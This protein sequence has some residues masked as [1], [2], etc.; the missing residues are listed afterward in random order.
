[1]EFG[2][3]ESEAEAGPNEEG[4]KAESMSSLDLSQSIKTQNASDHGRSSGEVDRM[5]KKFDRMSRQPTVEDYDSDGGLGS[6]GDR[7]NTGR[8]PVPFG[9]PATETMYA[10]TATGVQLPDEVE[11]PG[12]QAHESLAPSPRLSLESHTSSS[13]DGSN[14]PPG[15]QNKEP[16]K[17]RSDSRLPYSARSNTKSL[18]RTNTWDGRPRAESSLQSQNTSRKSVGNATSQGTKRVTFSRNQSQ[19][20]SEIDRRSS[21][22]RKELSDRRDSTGPRSQTATR[23]KSVR[24]ARSNNSLSSSE[25]SSMKGQQSFTDTS[26]DSD[27]SRTH[28]ANSARDVREPLGEDQSRSPSLSGISL[29][30]TKSDVGT[31]SDSPYVDYT[32]EQDY[33]SDGEDSWDSIE[34]ES[35]AQDWS[36]RPYRPRRASSAS[37]NYS[38]RRP[39]SH[40]PPRR[41]IFEVA[42]GY[43]PSEITSDDYPDYPQPSRASDPRFVAPGTPFPGLN[44]FYDTYPD[45]ASNPYAPEGGIYGQPFHPGYGRRMASAP[46]V[47]PPPPPPPPPFPSRAP[48]LPEL[49]ALLAPPDAPLNS[50][51]LPPEVPDAPSAGSYESDDDSRTVTDEPI[52]TPAHAKRFENASGGPP[53]AAVGLYVD[54]TSDVDPAR[55]A[56]LRFGASVPLH[57]TASISSPKW[58]E[59]SSNRNEFGHFHTYQRHDALVARRLRRGDGWQSIELQCRQGPPLP[60]L[61]GESQMEWL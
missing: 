13:T 43:A 9:G 20:S 39:R 34:A 46:F 56:Q 25:Q 16:R 50:E 52:N 47:S 7:G 61:D 36:S 45:Y 23:G 4:G 3:Q 11:E 53:D 6:S 17:K 57:L 38:L 42:P 26:S 59:S 1:M 8:Q 32:S 21:P 2:A 24:P 40:E 5:I 18:P 19:S 28:E 55:L 30:Y 10:R 29:D 41:R 27:S 44:P 35:Y 33:T 58:P 49:R 12:S 54:G 37:P 60:G 31:H 48:V 51:D 22:R 14:I 15:Y